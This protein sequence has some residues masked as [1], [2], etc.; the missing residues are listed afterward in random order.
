MN[1]LS[2]DR[3]VVM[4]RCWYYTN[5]NTSEYYD[6]VCI[7]V[8]NKPILISLNDGNRV[9]EG[10]RNVSQ[11]NGEPSV[12]GV[13]NY[14]E[15]CSNDSWN[16]YFYVDRDTV[17][18]GND[19]YSESINLRTFLQTL[20]RAC[21]NPNGV[22]CYYDKTDLIYLRFWDVDCQFY[23]KKD[24]ELYFAPVCEPG[25]ASSGVMDALI[26]CNDDV[27]SALGL[28]GRISDGRYY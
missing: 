14:L 16:E 27:R 15:Y 22:K 10:L 11:Y 23:L 26:Q 4:I 8:R 13:N 3:G 9:I 24:G 1:F 18:L 28:K 7:V 6:T 5:Y 2:L 12:I 20:E 25:D 17:R 19:N 21:S